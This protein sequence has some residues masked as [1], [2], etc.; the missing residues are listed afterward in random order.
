MILVIYHIIVIYVLK[1]LKVNGTSNISYAVRQTY[2]RLH[3]AHVCLASCY[4]SLV[5]HLALAYIIIYMNIDIYMLNLH[6]IYIYIYI[7]IYTHIIY[8]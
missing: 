7:Y 8:I 5:L 1:V 4:V 6:N 3:K 2:M